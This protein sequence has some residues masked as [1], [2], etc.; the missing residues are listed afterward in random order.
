[1]ADDN[2]EEII[3][4]AQGGDPDPTKVDPDP[5]KKDPDPSQD[6]P[7]AAKQKAAFAAMRVENKTLKEQVNQLLTQTK[8][9]TAKLND[10]NLTKKEETKLENQKDDVAERLAKIEAELTKTTQELQSEREG[11]QKNLIVEQVGA[12]KT[13]FNLTTDE[14]LQFAED[15]EKAGFNLRDN[16]RNM[17]NI[18]RALN[19]DKIVAK[20]VEKELLKK[21]L[22]PAAITGP[23]G[24][25]KQVGK[26]SLDGIISAAF[27]EQK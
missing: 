8:E 26:S 15:A 11:R 5:T 27:P 1:M 20:E 6:D 12:L 17:S 7:E 2:L 13:E 23:R 24:Q 10:P 21:G 9:L 18:Y 22:N 16:P 19:M 25:N 4:Q 14:L 3:R